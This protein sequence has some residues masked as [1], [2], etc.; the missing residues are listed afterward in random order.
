MELPEKRINGTDNIARYN[1]LKFIS[2]TILL[3]QKEFFFFLIE[4]YLIIL[5]PLSSKNDLLAQLV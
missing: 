2:L 1:S 3:R 4:K 5:H